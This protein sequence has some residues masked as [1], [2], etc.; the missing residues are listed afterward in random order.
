MVNADEDTVIP[1]GFPY[2]DNAQDWAV[3]NK[4]SLFPEV[5]GG[6]PIRFQLS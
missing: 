1:V 4:P 6:V 3:E 2:H 5:G